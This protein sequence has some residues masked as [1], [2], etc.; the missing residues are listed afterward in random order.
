MSVYMISWAVMP[1]VALPESLL[2]DLVGVQ[3]MV[4]G[5]GVLL[6]IALIAIALLLPGQRERQDGQASEPPA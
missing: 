2:A 6:L 4:G 5:V 1:F 3:W